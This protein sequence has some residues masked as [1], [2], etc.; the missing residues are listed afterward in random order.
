MTQ[1][2]APTRVTGDGPE[3]DTL[4]AYSPVLILQGPV[5]LTGARAHEAPEP[6]LEVTGNQYSQAR[7]LKLKGAISAQVAAHLSLLHTQPPPTPP[8][9][10]MAV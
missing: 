5:A 9:P 2:R 6:G 1:D 8:P 4:P 10:A 3:G 7:G